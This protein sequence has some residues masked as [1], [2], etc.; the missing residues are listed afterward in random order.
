MPPSD[1]EQ[2]LAKLESD[3][4]AMRDERTGLSPVRL[5]IRPRDEWP[6]VDPDTAPDIVVGYDWGYRTSWDSPLGQFPREVFVDNDET[7]S[8]DHSID[9]RLVPGVFLSNRRITIDDP[10]LFDL[11]VTVLDEFGVAPLPEMIGEGALE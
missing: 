6:G 4:L 2:V 1:Y 10:A 5:V 11:T 8:G 3:L 7:W 9:Y